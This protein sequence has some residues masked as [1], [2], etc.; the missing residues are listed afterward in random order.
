MF[1]AGPVC[2]LDGNESVAIVQFEGHLLEST[3]VSLAKV[4]LLTAVT[5]LS[6]SVLHTICLEGGQLET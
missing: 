1:S 4:S 5:A 2:I 3:T 6:I